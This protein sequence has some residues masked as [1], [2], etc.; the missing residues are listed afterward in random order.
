MT[1][2]CGLGLLDNLLSLSDLIINFTLLQLMSL[3]LSCYTVHSSLTFDPYIKLNCFLVTEEPQMARC[4]VNHGLSQ[5][6]E[7][8][9]TRTARLPAIH[10][11]F[12]TRL[13]YTCI[14]EVTNIIHYFLNFFSNTLSDHHSLP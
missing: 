2:I 8:C 11:R 9:T 10:H 3:F 12:N 6:S 4:V 1:I 7:H 13:L 14:H 5:S